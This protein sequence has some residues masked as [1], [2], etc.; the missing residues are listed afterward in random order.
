MLDPVPMAL[1]STP[2]AKVLIAGRERKASR[3]TVQRSLATGAPEQVAEGGG[4]LAAEATLVLDDQ[5]SVESTRV[6]SPWARVD[7]WP[8]RSGDEVSIELGVD[9]VDRPRL[10]GFINSTT[11]GSQAPTMT[12][13]AVDAWDT[14]DRR[15]QWPAMTTTMPPLTAGGPQLHVGITGAHMTDRLMRA[16]G[17]FCTYPLSSSSIFSAT[18]QGS[19]WP[20]VGS[21]LATQQATPRLLTGP[22]GIYCTHVDV[23]YQATGALPDTH[24]LTMNLHPALPL[25]QDSRVLVMNGAGTVGYSLAHIGSAGGPLEL[26]R[27]GAVSSTVIATLDRLTA[28]RVAVRVTHTQDQTTLVVRTN[29][30]RQAS[31]VTSRMDMSGGP[32][33]V[34]IAGDGP[35]GALLLDN[36]GPLAWRALQSVPNASIQYTSAAAVSQLRAIPAMELTSV[37][38]LLVE[39]SLAEF[40]ALN[41]DETGVLRWRSRGFMS[42]RP[43]AKTLVARNS[44]LQMQWRDDSSMVRSAVNVTGRNAH[45]SPPAST[46]RN[47]TLWEGKSAETVPRGQT[48]SEVVR[49]PDDEDW[50]LPDLSTRYAGRPAA[51]GEDPKAL[52]KGVESWVGGHVIDGNGEPQGWFTSADGSAGWEQISQRAFV[53]TITVGSSLPAGHFVNQKMSP[54]SAGLFPVRRNDP[55]PVLRSAQ[56]V[57]WSSR[58]AR[59]ALGPTTAPELNIDVGWW[60]Q[61]QALDELCE[62]LALQTATPTPILDS[63]RIDPDPSLQLGDHIAVLDPDVYGLTASGVIFSCADTWEVGVSADSTIELRLTS[64]THSHPTM[65]EVSA[66][67]GQSSFDTRDGAWGGTTFGSMDDAPLSR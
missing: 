33:T 63:V 46:V 14:L 10:R 66:R 57:Q 37:Q 21:V 22:Q 53:Y 3:I 28:Q 65:G 18:M 45:L 43:I 38:D 23:R 60:V 1:E 30:G 20:E 67:W 48:R 51:P 35:V 32:W 61:G 7:G 52:D 50:I 64:A 4:I 56:R 49:I 58:T 40:A 54:N 25:T 19:V 47:I 41:I 27:H 34:Q 8:P 2:T 6:A 26:R 42:S 17:Y 15:I 24:E 29:D 31:A 5:T 59:L 11:A 62:W 44:I 9:G 36:P 55:L 16:A 39:Q 13:R 12:C